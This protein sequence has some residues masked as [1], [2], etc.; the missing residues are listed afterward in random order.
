MLKFVYVFHKVL[1]AD[2]TI[3][4]NNKVHTAL[5]LDKNK[6]EEKLCSKEASVKLK[7]L[8]V[9][10]RKDAIF[11]GE[12][13]VYLVLIFLYQSFCFIDKLRCVSS[14]SSH[15]SLMCCYVQSLNL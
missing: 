9:R 8:E 1:H 14:I 5:V 2:V 3:N 12:C 15:R 10:S 6:S 7:C 4:I 11:T 13:L